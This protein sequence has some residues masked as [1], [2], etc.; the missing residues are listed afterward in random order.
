LKLLTKYAIPE[1][2]SKIRILIELSTEYYDPKYYK[3][4]ISDKY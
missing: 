4:L 1:Y 2:I 3:S